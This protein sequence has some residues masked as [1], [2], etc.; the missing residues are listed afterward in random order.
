MV[1]R[2]ESGTGCILEGL[3]EIEVVR[4]GLLFVTETEA[5]KQQAL[6]DLRIALAVSRILINPHNDH[7]ELLVRDDDQI[8]LLP[9]ATDAFLTHVPEPIYAP[10]AIAMQHDFE[11]LYPSL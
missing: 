10:V 4:M 5:Q 9:R 8:G 3:L 7:R 6:I 1:R 2:P 11:Q